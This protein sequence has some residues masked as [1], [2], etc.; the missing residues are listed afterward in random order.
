[1]S[2]DNNSDYLFSEDEDDICPLCCEDM[3]ITDKN[4]KPCPC[5]Y[6]I[7]QF[8]YNNIRTNPELNGKCPACRRLY[9]DKN[10]E[11]RNIT[12]E[13]WKLQKAKIEKKK[14]EKKLLEKE[15]K[16]AEQAKRHHLAGM[17]VIQ[18]NLVY[19]VGLNP[20]C[21]YD[22]LIPL[23]KSEKYFGQYGKINKIV[24]N[25][26]NPNQ[27]SS[28]HQSSSN[29]GYG[30][31][32]TFARKEDATRCI[33]A[34][35]GSISDG[36]VLKAAYGT[37]KY[38]S[39]YLRGQ[40]CPNPNCMFLHEPGEEA[41]SYSRHDL[42]SKASSK[43]KIE[44]YDFSPQNSPRPQLSQLNSNNSNIN[45]QSGNMFTSKP[46]PSE[47]EGPALPPTVSWAKVKP[48]GGS[49]PSSDPITAPVVLDISAISFKGVSDSLKH[50]DESNFTYS[51]DDKFKTPEFSISSNI[52]LFHCLDLGAL[53][54]E[55]KLGLMNE[56]DKSRLSVLTESLLFSPFTRNYNYRAYLQAANASKIKAAQAQAQA[57]AEAVA[58]G[59]PEQLKSTLTP[60]QIQ[61]QLQHSSSFSSGVNPTQ[62]FLQQRLMQQQQQQQQQKILDPRVSASASPIPPPPGLHSNIGN[63][64]K[65]N[66]Q[67]LLSQ[68]MGKKVTV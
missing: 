33:A 22:D 67:E 6:Q 44:D 10:I 66:S 60:S 46:L 53:P 20:P 52:R 1:M 32:V 51:I 7:C 41:D 2:Y 23:L 57:E 37:T 45:L 29:P 3:D 59:S 25:K 61:A 18:K 30:V 12:A 63:D 9:E 24:I 15:R 65:S 42:T 35:D 50:M 64:A 13:E 40:P 68:L 58:L 54:N 38:C 27:V 62:A 56:E 17:R 21:S 26:R 48:Q 47:N 19:V 14:R 31:Y 34:V 8:C 43:E 39:S 5:G 4:F 55:K 11:Y 28:F 16:D 36:K 49:L